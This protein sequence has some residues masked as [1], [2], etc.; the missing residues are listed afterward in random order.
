M[1][2][3]PLAA[4]SNIFCHIRHA[5]NL[6]R[7]CQVNFYSS[8]GSYVTRSDI[9]SQQIGLACSKERNTEHSIDD[10]ARSPRRRHA[11]LID[12]SG[13]V[14]CAPMPG[15][16]SEQFAALILALREVPP[17]STCDGKAETAYWAR[18]RLVAARVPGKSTR[19]GS[20]LNALVTS[21]MAGSEFSP[22]FGKS[23]NE[24]TLPRPATFFLNGDPIS[25]RRVTRYRVG[26]NGRYQAFYAG[27]AANSED[28]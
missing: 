24:A 26:R 12:E 23:N 18:M 3:D 5:E 17:N 21:H 9:R 11:S 28:P 10:R 7:C 16:T 13:T 15:W 14:I 19:R 1:Q 22:T 2:T 8:E 6:S 27:A 20:V 4:F 25:G